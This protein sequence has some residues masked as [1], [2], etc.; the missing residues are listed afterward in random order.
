MPQGG[1][2][3]AAIEERFLVPVYAGPHAARWISLYRGLTRP[4]LG[5]GPLVESSAALGERRFRVFCCGRPKRFRGLL[6]AVFDEVGAT[7][8]EGRRRTTE[9]SRFDDLPADVLAVEVHPAFAPRFRAAGWTIV[10]EAVRWTADVDA[11]PLS[12]R[13]RAAR[14]L[15]SDLSLIAA[16]GYEWEEGGGAEDWR[17]FLEG[18][19]FPY[20]RRRF[21]GDAWLPGRAFVR[22]L[23]SRGRI[24]FAL[25]EGRRVSG[26]CVLRRGRHG[27]M[28]MIGV[29]DGD[30]ELVHRGAIA[31]MYKF[32]VQWARQQGLETVDIGRTK[33]FLTDGTAWY[34]SKWGFVP[35][36]D[37]LAHL[38][39]V[40]VVPDASAVRGRLTQL[41][42]M[43]ELTDGVHAFAGSPAA[44]STPA[45]ASA[46]P[47]PEG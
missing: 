38:V 3:L 19:V 21:G 32:L 26:L 12:P 13:G 47:A 9:P 46:T 40:R 42:L 35:Q 16:Q 1:R 41:G 15:R 22:A 37:P 45:C 23:R 5:S 6:G 17:L 31:V 14:T 10:P 33:P 34:K 25:Q 43:H 2:A 27:W 29:L 11:L 20:A 39:A 4:L 30:T 18:M 7:R 36:P 28:P 8:A 24:L 44:A